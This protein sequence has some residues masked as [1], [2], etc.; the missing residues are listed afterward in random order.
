MAAKSEY[1]RI[2]DIMPYIDMTM[3][4]LATG[5]DIEECVFGR[6]RRM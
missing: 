3:P 4:P 2:D 5:A 6:H 1:G